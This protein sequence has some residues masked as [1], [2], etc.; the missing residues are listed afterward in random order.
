[1]ATL[2]SVASVAERSAA[3]YVYVSNA[4]DG[5]VGMYT[6]LPDGALQPGARVKAEK[7][8]MPMSVSPDKRFLIAGVRTKPS[9]RTPTRSIAVLACSRWSVRGRWRRASRTSRWTEAHATCSEPRTGPIWS[10][11]TRSAPTDASAHRYR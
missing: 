2:V 4:E 1:M 3:T 8:V 6:L 5:D 10:A 11:S 9:P 7:L